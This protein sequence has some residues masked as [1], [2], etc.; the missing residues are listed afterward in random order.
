MSH[1]PVKVAINDTFGD[2]R[3]RHGEGQIPSK[4]TTRAVRVREFAIAESCEPSLYFPFQTTRQIDVD[5][6]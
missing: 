4:L 2:A 3:R 1:Q 6:K 5:R